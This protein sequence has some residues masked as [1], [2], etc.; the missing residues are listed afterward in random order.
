MWEFA[1]TQ[2]YITKK[3][4]NIAERTRVLNMYYTLI[5]GTGIIEYIIHPYM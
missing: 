3:I 4:A 1:Q 5:L 2:N